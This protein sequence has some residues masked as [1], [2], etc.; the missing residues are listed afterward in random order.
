[1]T[2]QV[3]I[4]KNL[5]EHADR[6]WDSPVWSFRPAV[7]DRIHDWKTMAL[8]VLGDFANPDVMRA[9]R[10]VCQSA[11]H[12]RP[13]KEGVRILR[14]E[15]FDGSVLAS[16]VPGIDHPLFVTKMWTSLAGNKL[17]EVNT[18]LMHEYVIG[19]QITNVLRTAGLPHFAYMYTHYWS[20]EPIVK[21]ETGEAWLTAETRAGRPSD[22]LHIM[23]EYVPGVR[24]HDAVQKGLSAKRL[25]SAIFQ[26]LFALSAAE[27]QFGLRHGDLHG[28]NIMY[29][30]LGSTRVQRYSFE[31]REYDL[32]MDHC[33]VIIDFGMSDGRIHDR[34]HVVTPR[35][36]I[37]DTHNLAKIIADEKEQKQM[38][39][40]LA[41]HSRSTAA[42]RALL[43]DFK[44]D[45]P[46]LVKVDDE[47]PQPWFTPRTMLELLGRWFTS[48]IVS[49]QSAHMDESEDVEQ[50]GGGAAAK[51]GEAAAGDFVDTVLLPALLTILPPAVHD[52]VTLDS[53]L[54]HK[55]SFA[56]LFGRLSLV[57]QEDTNCT[58]DLECKVVRVDSRVLVLGEASVYWIAT[59][60]PRAFARV[61]YHW[62]PYVQQLEIRDEQLWQS[63]ALGVFLFSRLR[64]SCR[65][66][67]VQH[68][69][70][71]EMWGRRVHLLQWLPRATAAVLQ[72]G[73]LKDDDP[74]L[75]DVSTVDNEAKASHD[76]HMARSVPAM[77]LELLA[78]DGPAWRTA[79]LQ[80]L[81]AKTP[82]KLGLSAVDQVETWP[83]F[84]GLDT[85]S[86][87]LVRTLHTR[88]PAVLGELHVEVVDNLLA[89]AE[90]KTPPARRLVVGRNVILITS[91]PALSDELVE[92]NSPRIRAKLDDTKSYI[93]VS[94]SL[95]SAVAKN[96]CKHLQ[97]LV[98]SSVAPQVVVPDEWKAAL[99]VCT[100]LVELPGPVDTSQWTQDT[101]AAL[102]RPPLLPHLEVFRLHKCPA[103][104]AHV[105][106]AVIFWHW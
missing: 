62:L 6:D 72:T 53:V 76:T 67:T 2:E 60:G 61:V 51:R 26:L 27:L 57:H 80:V 19:T 39:E 81:A 37:P 16:S 59:Y 34:Y 15:G 83:A 77:Q 23:Y 105:L 9:M 74:L 86:A 71:P 29:R 14:A 31:G 18:S 43:A 4:Q 41:G 46:R 22:V 25:Q 56:D 11:D 101:V 79:A 48:S 99:A 13:Q 44:G 49:E 93:H 89:T 7:S 103:A 70:A 102:F 92:W 28:G 69:E 73:P 96:D 64:A 66:I 85:L 5:L 95:L 24:L 30:P 78:T 20:T 10:Y 21:E 106:A 97:R 17:V 36:Q 35:G 100:E 90:L 91:K 68:K 47:P 38:I 75:Q 45:K 12:R 52:R 65:S 1:M 8:D 94:P 42:L 98:L 84:A 40:I 104:T 54:E 88:L 3:L 55:Q 32:E 63:E 82:R 33:A 87:G 50:K 58:P